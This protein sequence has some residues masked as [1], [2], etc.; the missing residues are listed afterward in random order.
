[1]KATRNSSLL[2]LSLLLTLVCAMFLLIQFSEFTIIIEIFSQ[3]MF[4]ESLIKWHIF[5]LSTSFPWTRLGFLSFVLLIFQKC[6]L[7][8]SA[9]HSFC[10]WGIAF[11]SLQKNKFC[12]KSQWAKSYNL[13]LKTFITR[14]NI[15]QNQ[16]VSLVFS[17][18]L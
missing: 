3:F 12:I 9:Y 18:T 7:A 11:I 5:L 4:C 1:M 14:V 8:Y 13:P 6:L 17:E 10:I 16:N 2:Y 15:E